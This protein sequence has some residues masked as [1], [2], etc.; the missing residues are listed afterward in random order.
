M[1]RALKVLVVDDE[2]PARRRLRD[3]L[4]E[5]PC[6]IEV[7]G[8]AA[9]GLQALAEVHVLRPDLVLLDIQM[10]G[11]GGLEVARHLAGLAHPPAVVFTTAYDDYAL[12]AFEVRA[13]DYLLKPVR[14]ER[15][16]EALARVRPLRAQDA[17]GLPPRRHLLAAERGRVQL[18]PVEEVLYLRAELKYVTARTRRH[19]HVLD[20]SLTQIEQ[21]FPNVFLRIHRNCLVGRRHLAGFERQG[22]GEEARWVA[23]LTDWPERLPVSR[24]QLQLIREL[25]G[26]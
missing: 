8:E 23:V 26:R 13:L 2:A 11:M 7:V 1:G 9:D 10:P 24:R 19:E 15:L 14:A 5:T 18:I 17:E 3:L 25:R 20:A 4:A 12:Q 21:E 6:P 22:E 16:A